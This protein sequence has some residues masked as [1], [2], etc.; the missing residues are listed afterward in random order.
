MDKTHILSNQINV[1]A[2]K[3]IADLLGHEYPSILPHLNKIDKAVNQPVILTVFGEFSA[4]K[5]KFLNKLL[6]IDTLP[7]SIMPRTATVTK[8]IY[9]ETEKV[10]VEY[11]IDGESVLQK[12]NGYG[13]LSELH[14]AKE[15]NDPLFFKEI[16]NIK[17]LRVYVNNPILKRFTLIDTPGFNHDEKMD[18][19]TLSVLKETDIGIWISDFSQPAK[20]TEFESLEKIKEFVK[21]LHL[22]VNKAD[23]H[24]ENNEDFERVKKE[25]FENLKEN[26][27]L[28]FFENNEIYLIS[29]KTSMDFWDGKY[30]QFRS[31]F[32]RNVLNDD[33][34]LSIKILE[35]SFNQLLDALKKEK[36]KYQSL[37]SHIS[38]IRIVMDSTNFFDDF[39]HTLFNAIRPYLKNVLDS[40][41]EYYERISSLAN[42]KL[43]S[44]NDYIKE[45]LYDDVENF[46]TKLKGKYSR[47]LDERRWP[48]VA[49]IINY[50]NK[51]LS[52]L[53]ETESNIKEKLKK[54]KMFLELQLEY[55]KPSLYRLAAFMCCLDYI[56]II[57]S[58]SNSSFF[59][60]FTRSG[61]T[62][63]DLKFNQLSDQLRED[64]KSDITY[65][66]NNELDHTL[67]LIESVKDKKT[68]KLTQAMLKIDKDYN[69][70]TNDSDS[71]N[72]KYR[73]VKDIKN[74]NHLQ[75]FITNLKRT[76]L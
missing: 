40:L 28:N 43:N 57:N 44:V 16:D 15:I 14:R 1:K 50:V 18:K 23:V 48:Y 60:K 10:E 58:E 29:C 64:L 35:V 9:G 71:K 7:V 73:S 25:I 76:S 66:Y 62:S 22:V 46:I 39:N 61:D 6:G 69:E 59:N 67:S 56:N 68:E 37:T 75:N 42:T 19:K 11:L 4:G 21:I 47:L 34:A 54:I 70:N 24:V 55:K 72:V 12:K 38:G 27:F 31:A 5:S 30:E 32:A 51:L 45:L 17:E 74:L 65:F 26:G 53:P 3:E 41:D 63:D 2:V 13:I 20:K 52:E 33:L 36:E 49:I 8:V